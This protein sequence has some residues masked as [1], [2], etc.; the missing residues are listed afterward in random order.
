M[1]SLDGQGAELI[2]ICLTALKRTKGF[3][4]KIGKVEGGEEY[5]RQSTCPQSAVPDP[6]RRLYAWGRHEPVLTAVLKYCL[7][8][9]SYDLPTN[10]VQGRLHFNASYHVSLIA[11]VDILK[12]TSA[13]CRIGMSP[14]VKVHLGLSK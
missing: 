2:P 5:L 11:R 7:F 4:G 12:G 10:A 6:N 13:L 14:E 9:A 8:N 1:E 3:T